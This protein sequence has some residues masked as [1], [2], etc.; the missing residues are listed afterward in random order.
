M[1]TEVAPQFIRP[2]GTYQQMSS[3]SRDLVTLVQTVTF[4]RIDLVIQPLSLSLVS[5]LA[6]IQSSTRTFLV[7]RSD[8]LY[9]S[10]N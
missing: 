4:Q 10:L 9:T 6:S 3:D 1:T 2:L 5:A 8:G 7:T